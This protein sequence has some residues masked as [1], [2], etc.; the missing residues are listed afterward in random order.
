MEQPPVAK[1]GHKMDMAADSISTEMEKPT[2]QLKTEQ[3]PTQKLKEYK[4]PGA[5]ETNALCQND[6]RNC[7]GYNWNGPIA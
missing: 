1:F 3:T 4:I 7:M 2:H 5:W 6:W